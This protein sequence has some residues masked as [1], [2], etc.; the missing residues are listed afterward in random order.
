MMVQ[1]LIVEALQTPEGELALSR[2]MRCWW[3]ML[4]EGDRMVIIREVQKN[5]ALKKRK[6]K[7]NRMRPLGS[8]Q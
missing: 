6:E 7:S 8:R 5:W 2:A 4:S 3:G 1:E